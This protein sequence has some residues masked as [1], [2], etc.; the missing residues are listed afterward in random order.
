[1]PTPI[2]KPNYTYDPTKIKENGVDRMRFELGDTMFAPGELTAALCD[3][4]YEAAMSQYSTWKRKKLACLSAIMM[5][6]SHEVDTKVDAVSYSLSQRFEHY[7]KLY[8]GLRN[9]LKV[10]AGPGLSASAIGCNKPPYF[11]EDMQA[12]PANHGRGVR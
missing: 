6:Y 5:K 2:P 9:E 10:S 1:M 12:N 8:D 11:Y 7:K 3:E 4:E